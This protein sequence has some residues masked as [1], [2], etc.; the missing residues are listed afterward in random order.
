MG[1]L[2]ARHQD[3]SCQTSQFKDSIKGQVGSILRLQL[4]I[5]I[6][7]GVTPTDSV[8]SILPKG[9]VI[10]YLVDLLKNSWQIAEHSRVLLVYDS[11]QG[12]FLTT[13]SIIFL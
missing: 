4:F 6:V 1:C 7:L 8:R 12:E 2:V 11:F 5:M 10:L 9:S 3:M 13:G